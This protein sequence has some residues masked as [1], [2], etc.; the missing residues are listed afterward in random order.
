MKLLTGTQMKAL[1]RQAIDEY[2]IPSLELMENAGNQIVSSMFEWN[3]S[4]AEKRITIVCGKGNNGGDGMVV[5][6]LLHEKN[7]PLEVFCLAEAEACSE[8]TKQQIQLLK[9]NNIDVKHLPTEKEFPELKTSLDK[10]DVIV[11]ALFGVGIKGAVQGHYA[12][13]IRMIN[14]ADAKCVAVDIP[15]G[16]DADMGHVEGEAVKADLTVTLG[17]PKIGLLLYPGRSYA[18]KLKVVSIGYSDKLVERFDSPYTFLEQNYVAEKLPPRSDYSHKGSFG[19]V[20]LFAG[21]KKMT[22]AAIL[23]GKAALRSGTGLLYL[24]SNLY[25]PLRS[26]I[27]TQVFES[28]DDIAPAGNMPSKF[29]DFSKMDAVALGPGLSQGLLIKKKIRKWISKIN[30]P[31]IIDADGINALVNHLDLLKRR[32]I[33]TVLTPHPGEFAR[34]TGLSIKEIETNRFKVAQEFAK[35]HNVILVLK[36]VPTVI[37]TPEGQ[38]FVNST[39]NSGLAKGGSGDVLTGMMLAL[40][41]QGASLLDAAC[42]AVWVHGFTADYLRDHMGM[43]ERGMLPSDLIEAL[44][45]V[46]R[47]LETDQAEGGV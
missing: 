33:G 6:R 35:E 20:L 29:E 2:G 30:T 22:G 9:Q 16:V 40:A 31:L 15:S 28:L 44:P 5:A 11:D 23:S 21:S 18:G 26:I 25:E 4:L 13:A 41:G 10:A 32:E 17:L 19:K 39:G 43:S 8:E 24:L 36:G 7:V 27:S 3:E 46:W 12:I 42:C 47:L 37:V 1:D 45:K 34:L 38:I 14:Q